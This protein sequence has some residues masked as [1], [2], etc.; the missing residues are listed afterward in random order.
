MLPFVICRENGGQGLS[1]VDPK[2]CSMDGALN[3]AFE[4][5]WYIRGLVRRYAF[6][7]HRARSTTGSFS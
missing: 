4:L 5:G 6:S 1:Y 7:A 3:S 2:K